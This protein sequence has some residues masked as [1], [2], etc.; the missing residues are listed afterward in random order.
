MRVIVPFTERRPEVEAAMPAAEWVDVSGSDGA[1]CELLT[2]LWRAGE[3]FVIVEH[4]IVPPPGFVDGLVA[5]GLGWCAGSYPY[6][7][8]GAM[9]GMGC[10]KFSD[11]LMALFP[12]LMTTVGRMSS[13]EHPAG[14]WCNLDARIQRYLNG[15]GYRPHPHGLVGHLSPQ[16]S[17]ACT[18]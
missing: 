3:T 16:R 4:D 12:S 9:I 15:E 10:V 11:N 1:Y 18:F 17:H 14:H 6:E 13:L 8:F 2:G 7:G 5:C